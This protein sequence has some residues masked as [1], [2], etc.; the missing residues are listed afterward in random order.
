MQPTSV[1]ERHYEMM[2]G[3]RLSVCHVPRHNSSTE[4][5]GKPKM[6]RMEA[7]NTGNP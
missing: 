3:V 1:G 7:G 5:H 4:R 6:G 2:G